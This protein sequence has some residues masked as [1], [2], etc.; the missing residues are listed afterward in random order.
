MAAWDSQVSSG[1]YCQ[2]THP[3]FV[4]DFARLLIPPRIDF[5]ALIMGENAEGLGGNLRVVG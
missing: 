3:Q 2:F 4:E 5:L 1:N